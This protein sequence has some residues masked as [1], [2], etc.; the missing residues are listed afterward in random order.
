MNVGGPE[1]GQ[2][3]VRILYTL[4]GVRPVT[5]VDV[6]VKNEICWATL[7]A[8]QTVLTFEILPTA[9]RIGVQ[10]IVFPTDNWLQLGPRFLCGSFPKLGSSIA[11]YWCS[12]FK[13]GSSITYSRGRF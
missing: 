13:L 4:R 7:E 2:N 9:L 6:G 8:G 12:F 3:G 1:L 11:G 10:L 5:N